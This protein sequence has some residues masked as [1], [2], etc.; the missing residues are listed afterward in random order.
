ME[1]FLRCK[2]AKSVFTLR[3]IGQSL[4][5]NDDAADK[6]RSVL[7]DP[8]SATILR[9]Q[10][11][12]INELQNQLQDFAISGRE[13]FASAITFFTAK[14]GNA[15]KE[16]E[17]FSNIRTVLEIL[18]LYSITT[19]DFS[20]TWDKRAALI[21]KQTTILS[22][23]TGSPDQTLY[24]LEASSTQDC[25]R[26]ATLREKISRRERCRSII[27]KKVIELAN[28]KPLD[29]PFVTYDQES[30]IHRLNALKFVQLLQPI[31][32]YWIAMAYCLAI[33]HRTYD[34]PPVYEDESN[35][36]TMGTA[37]TAISNEESE[38]IL[39]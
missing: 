33:E 35:H 2:T 29:F 4:L 9:Q 22:K 5:R 26:L 7:I 25:L 38:A 10:D 3:Q 34:P 23:N 28:S 24:S 32:H 8:S 12:N 39:E 16:D 20:W 13:T 27:I 36:Q 14:I 6:W 1:V 19:S 30:P 18:V 31:G 11:G 15:E 37:S 17:V 21:G